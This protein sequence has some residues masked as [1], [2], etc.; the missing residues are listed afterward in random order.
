MGDH[1]FLE[2]DIS[3]MKKAADQVVKQQAH[4]ITDG[5]DAVY[6]ASFAGYQATNIAPLLQQ[7]FVFDNNASL[8]P[9]PGELESSGSGAVGPAPAAGPPSQVPIAQAPAGSGDPPPTIP[10]PPQLPIHPPGQPA[11]FPP[12]SVSPDAPISEP[13]LKAT[14]AP[15]LTN[16]PEPVPPPLIPYVPQSQ[17]SQLQGQAAGQAD[18]YLPMFPN[19]ASYDQGVYKSWKE[20][21]RLV[22]IQ[23][24]LDPNGFFS[25]RTDGWRFV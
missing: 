10:S 21:D 9:A 16:N 2:L 5:I 12:H 13:P 3:W 17:S 19:D 20:Y 24:A 23:K 7:R 18:K 25:H 14:P 6:R 4:S 22:Q 1:I 15:A 8:A 11:S